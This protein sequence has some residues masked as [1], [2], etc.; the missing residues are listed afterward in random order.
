MV[1]M[2]SQFTRLTIIYWTVYSDTAQRKHQNSAS[3]AF[4]RGIH[5]D[6]WIPAQMASNAENVSIL[7]RH[8]VLKHSWFM[9]IQCQH[10]SHYLLGPHHLTLPTLCVG[11][12]PVLQ[13]NHHPAQINWC[14]CHR[15]WRISQVLISPTHC[16]MSFSPG[17]K[18]WTCMGYGLLI[19]SWAS[20]AFRSQ[21]ICNGLIKISCRCGLSSCMALTHVPLVSGGEYAQQWLMHTYIELVLN[22]WL[23]FWQVSFQQPPRIQSMLFVSCKFGFPFGELTVY[24]N[25]LYA[26][27]ENIAIF[28]MHILSFGGEYILSETE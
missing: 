12:H 21:R 3:L 13:E 5:R 24:S 25:N 11:L 1:A 26:I 8:H 2:A 6:R 10:W 4:V 7:W 22:L 17:R 20:A 9:C 14:R 28:T 23:Q 15:T 16:W 27:T 18:C 19:S